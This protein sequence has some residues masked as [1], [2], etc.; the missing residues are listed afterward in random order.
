MIPVVNNKLELH[1]SI[2]KSPFKR[3]FLNALTTSNYLDVFEQ[4]FE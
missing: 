2:Q 4:L 1:F 3:A